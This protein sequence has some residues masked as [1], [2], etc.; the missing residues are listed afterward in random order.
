M[1]EVYWRRSPQHKSRI[2]LLRRGHGGFSFAASTSGAKAR[3]TSEAR[4]AQPSLE[5]LTASI[6]GVGWQ[7]QRLE[8]GVGWGTVINTALNRRQKNVSR[9]IMD[10]FPNS[11]ANR[12]CPLGTQNSAFLLQISR[13][14]SCADGNGCTQKV[15][16]ATIALPCTLLFPLDVPSF[17]FPKPNNSVKYLSQSKCSV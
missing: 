17:Y 16:H 14:Y 12:K 8:D 3:S 1:E 15:R 9:C 11:K 7:V 6:R 4:G 5:L 2:I 10:F 13:K